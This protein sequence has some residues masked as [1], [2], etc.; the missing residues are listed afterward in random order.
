MTQVFTGH[1]CFGEYL[2]RI[3]KKN[4]RVR[5]FCDYECD[6]AQ[7]TLEECPAW[8]GERE[9]LRAKVGRDLSLPTLVGKMVEGEERE[10]VWRAVS[11]FCEKVMSQK[12]EMERER[13]RS[14]RRGRLV[15]SLESREE[16]DDPSWLPRRRG[17]CG[18]GRGRVGPRPA[19]DDTGVG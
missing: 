2:G 11:S 16:R 10:E 17:R 5:W 3:G 9:E 4:S 8:A 19:P 6:T 7:H 1:G 15:L 13:E 12:E 14:G 18:G